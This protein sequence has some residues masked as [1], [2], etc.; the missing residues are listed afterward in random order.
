MW[1]NTLGFS[2]F[3]TLRHGKPDSATLQPAAECAPIATRLL[4]DGARPGWE[5]YGNAIADQ[6]PTEL[7]NPTA[8]NDLLFSSGT[9]GRPKGIK[10]PST[11]APAGSTNALLMPIQGLFGIVPEPVNPLPPPLHHPPPHAPRPHHS[12][13]PR[14]P[15]RASPS[16]WPAACAP[17]PDW[18][19]SSLS[20]RLRC[21]P[22]SLRN[23]RTCSPSPT[24]PQGQP[25]TNQAI[26]SL[27]RGRIAVNSCATET[28]QLN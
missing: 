22:V 23:T 7:E 18:R 5:S 11:G 12:A 27:A 21:P 28:G 10:W 19:C 15:A 26:Q 3:G 6:P 14:L 16:T 2:L 8:G 25:T 9:T 20:S 4:V 17:G 13:F 1:T 24:C